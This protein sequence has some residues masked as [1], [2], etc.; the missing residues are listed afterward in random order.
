MNKI[1]I[2]KNKWN[3]VFL[4]YKLVDVSLHAEWYMNRMFRIQ[5]WLKYVWLERTKKMELIVKLEELCNVNILRELYEHIDRGKTSDKKWQQR[6]LIIRSNFVNNNHH[7]LMKWN[8]SSK[9]NKRMKKMIINKASLLIVSNLSLL[10]CVW[11]V[12]IW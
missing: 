10:V 12:W 5:K 7:Q 2:T 11:N 9:G 1:H 4:P 6:L 3:K 8:F